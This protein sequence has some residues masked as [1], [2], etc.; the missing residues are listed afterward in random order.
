MCN[1]DKLV[2]IS[3][4]Q[5]HDGPQ[6]TVLKNAMFALVAAVWQQAGDWSHTLTAMEN[7]GYVLK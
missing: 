1:L 3:I 7:L 5:C 4:R 2:K 6:P